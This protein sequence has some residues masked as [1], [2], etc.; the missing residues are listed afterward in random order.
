MKKVSSDNSEKNQ[1]RL[2]YILDGA[3]LGSW[4]WWLETNEV[5]FDRRWCEMLG[6]QKEETP[7][8]LDTWTLR[9]H[10]EDIKGAYDDINAYLNGETEVYENIHR[11]R[12]T[13]G[14][15]IWILDRGRVSSRAEDGR[16]LRFTGTH[17]DITKY[18]ELE[19][20][21]ENIQRI[22]KIGG[23][24]VMKSGDLLVTN[25]SARILGIKA[26]KLSRNEFVSIFDPSET[27]RVS[28]ILDPNSIDRTTYEVFKIANFVGRNKWIA[29]SAEP[30]TNALGQT[31]EVRGSLQDI[32]APHIQSLE[33]SELVKRERKYVEQIKQTSEKLEKLIETIPA[34]IF[35]TDKEGRCTFVNKTW[36]QLTNLSP[37][38]AS[39]THWID[40]LHAVKLEKVNESWSNFVN[41]GQS[42][43]LV[44]HCRKPNNT[45]NIIHGRIAKILDAS[46]KIEGYLGSLQDITE[47]ER[48]RTVL[49]RTARELDQFFS[50][51]MDPLCIADLNGW[52]LRINPAWTRIL[53]FSQQELLS[54]P[55]IEFIHSDD[56]YLATRELERIKGGDQSCP[57]ESRFRCKDGSW[58]I[59]R[60]AFA[61]DVQNGLLYGVAHDI[62]ISRRR[63]EE[64]D[65][66]QRVARIGS[67]SY[68]LKTGKIFWSPQMFRLFP[69][70]PTSPPP[71]FE[72][73][74]STI[75]PDDLNIWSSTVQKCLND[76]LPYK[77]RFRSVFPENKYVWIEAHGEAVKIEGAIVGLR[78]TCQDIS[79]LVRIEEE[80]RLERSKAMQNSKLASLGEMSA[81][82]AHEINNPLTVIMGLC[83][84]LPK[85]TT[86]HEKFKEKVAIIENAAAR[87]ERIVGGLKKFARHSVPRTMRD[88]KLTRIIDDALVIT[89]A[90]I[91]KSNTAIIKEITDDPTI[92]CDEVE[93][94]QIIVNLINNALDAIKDQS[95]SWIKITLR[96]TNAHVILQVIDSGEGIKNEEVRSRLF[97]PFF[98]TKEVGEGT[99][100]G[101]SIS[102]GIAQDHNATLDLVDQDNTCFEI[103]FRKTEKSAA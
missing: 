33:L 38:V 51:S 13:N 57:F 73:H 70:D 96:E 34:G 62:T 86:D 55:M 25:E 15:W 103:K 49:E 4:D 29:I 61:P 101:L 41:E 1:E 8:I 75:H 82:I 43:D 90:K 16:P 20:L 67:W 6:L 89:G 64:L 45:E 65:Q 17:L 83:W 5:A 91:R 31:I 92:N 102:R 7:Q 71:T 98:T 87:I 21:A 97:Q 44:Y 99:G 76:G 30:V 78:G 37:E 77:M 9:V 39:G 95:E 80:A 59:L 68:D 18:R 63:E 23:W 100:L 60:F 32:T 47:Q 48:M 54:R 14:E 28:K 74:R 27:A 22:A 19:T 52:L 24:K 10:P 56:I 93:I 66:A 81:G 46:G 72:R 11:M 88:H 69:E 42:F 84:A 40:T 35:A 58:R 36:S 79:E 12:H 26:T 85:Y 94:E 2:E 53:G 50:V 3:G